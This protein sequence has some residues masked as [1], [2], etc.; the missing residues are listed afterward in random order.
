MNNLK[1]ESKIDL[2]CD[3][4]DQICSSLAILKVHIRENHVSH[5][6]SETELN[7][8][9]KFT[10]YFI[11]GEDKITQ[12]CEVVMLEEKCENYPCYYCGEIIISEVGLGQHRTECHQP[13]I[14][15]I[16][17]PKPVHML[18]PLV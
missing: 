11:T 5:K 13:T 16:S 10:Q 8:E 2:E 4:C 3:Y 7:N 15:N 12:T 9:E 18:H 17:V 14:I 6:T 1:L